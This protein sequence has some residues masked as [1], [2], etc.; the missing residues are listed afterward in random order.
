MDFME[1]MGSGRYSDMDDS[2]DEYYPPPRAARGQQRQQ[3]QHLPQQGNNKGSLLSEF[4]GAFEG[5]E[6]SSDLLQFGSGD[7]FGSGLDSP[8]SS[9]RATQRNNQQ[10]GKGAAGPGKASYMDED[11]FGWGQGNASSS[12]DD[13]GPAAAKQLHDAWKQDTGPDAWTGYGDVAFDDQIAAVAGD[14]PLLQQ[15]ASM[16]DNASSMQPQQ[17]Q[18]R[19]GRQQRQQG[20]RGGRR[21]GRTGSAG[22]GSSDRADS[23]K[24][25]A[26]GP[27]DADGFEDGWADRMMLD[28]KNRVGLDDAMRS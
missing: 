18:A 12:F 5:L 1:D 14:D 26:D 9:S 25:A 8:S 22:R 28:G 15:L 3:Q 4:A 6:G 17:R 16:P 21:G 2:G 24:L 19:G 20:T 23:W 11:G 13:E 10:R 7:S 27:D